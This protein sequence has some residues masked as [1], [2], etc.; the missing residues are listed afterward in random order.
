MSLV[1]QVTHIKGFG[2]SVF[3]KLVP[4]IFL[5]FCFDYL[6]FSFSDSNKKSCFWKDRVFHCTVLLIAQSQND[7]RAEPLTWSSRH[8]V[9]QV[10]MFA[11]DDEE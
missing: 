1:S 10:D 9:E 7:P 3:I 4:A 2:L 6:N 11:M 8:G 5:C